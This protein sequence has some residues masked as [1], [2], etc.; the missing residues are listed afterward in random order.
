[1]RVKRKYPTRDLLMLSKSGAECTPSFLTSLK[2]I[3]ESELWPSKRYLASMLGYALHDIP[4]RTA[5]MYARI[6]AQTWTDLFDEPNDLPTICFELSC[7][8]N[9]SNLFNDERDDLPA[10][11]FEVNDWVQK[12]VDVILGVMLKEKT[13]FPE[14]T[15]GEFSYLI[16]HML[17]IQYTWY[18]FWDNR[19]QYDNYQLVLLTTMF[20]TPKL[21]E[22]ARALIID[23]AAVLL[24]DPFLVPTIPDCSKSTKCCGDCVDRLSRTLEDV[25]QS[26]RPKEH[27]SHYVCEQ[28]LQ[29]LT[30]K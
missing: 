27:R 17:G 19:L 7:K 3:F 13:C 16:Q 29:Q 1:M 23:Y 12:S 26:R 21:P 8:D 15:W 4:I 28:C 25:H 24:P 11:F 14:E 18:V 9:N 10:N 2:G 20:G 6:I 30:P 5:V 22:N